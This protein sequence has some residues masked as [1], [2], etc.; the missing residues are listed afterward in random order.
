MNKFSFDEMREI[1]RE[2]TNSLEKYSKTIK[3]YFDYNLGNGGYCDLDDKYF[4]NLHIIPY[5]RQIDISLIEKYKPNIIDY[6]GGK[7]IK[8]EV[9]ELD[10]EEETKMEDIL[11]WVHEACEKVVNK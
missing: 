11:T 9:L 3:T 2:F 10:N 4:I 7:T 8:S 5:P 6:V 1:Q